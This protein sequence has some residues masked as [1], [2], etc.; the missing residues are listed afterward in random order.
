M[1]CVKAAWR[2][3]WKRLV[4]ISLLTLPLHQRSSQAL[5]VHGKLGQ[6]LLEESDWMAETQSPI[7]DAD[8]LSL[9]FSYLLSIPLFSLSSTFLYQL[10]KR[11]TLTLRPFSETQAL[12]FFGT[13]S[14]LIHGS[15]QSY[16]MVYFKH[17][18]TLLD[19]MVVSGASQR[20]WLGLA[21]KSLKDDWL[22]YCWPL[23]SHHA[24][25]IRAILSKAMA[26]PS[27]AGEQETA[28]CGQ[29]EWLCDGQAVLRL[30]DELSELAERETV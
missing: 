16:T 20:P 11:M 27:L 12:L 30:L 18:L 8:M 25:S 24:E 9:L 21:V 5:D 23:V 3:E 1:E 22:P 13:L 26:E 6:F 29:I 15:L 28:S 17:F 19:S 4:L 14:K 7:H 2:P 10:L